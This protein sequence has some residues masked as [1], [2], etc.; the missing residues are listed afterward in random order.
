MSE[1]TLGTSQKPKTCC[2][3]CFYH[4]WG[5]F[6]FVLFVS[7]MG[8]KTTK[9]GVLSV[10]SEE[11]VNALCLCTL[12]PPPSRLSS[13]DTIGGSLTWPPCVRGGA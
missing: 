11:K 8:G 12:P 6:L 2:F 4:Q 10:H 13:D 7:K 9:K 3:S 5:F 1:V